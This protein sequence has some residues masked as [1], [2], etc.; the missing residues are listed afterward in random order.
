MIRAMNPTP[1]NPS[2]I[3]RNILAIES[4]INA[5]NI[6][7]LKP[8]SPYLYVG[9]IDSSLGSQVLPELIRLIPFGKRYL[10]YSSYSVIEFNT[11]KEALEEC[12]ALQNLNLYGRKLILNVLRNEQVNQ[13]L[14]PPLED[15]DNSGK[16]NQETKLQRD[17]TPETESD[18]INTVLPGSPSKEQTKAAAKDHNL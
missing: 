12:N 3:H 10:M 14:L 5:L 13:F 8:Y 4:R 7:A 15:V 2:T 16:Q 9:N 11:N 18:S 6:A 1:T 17:N